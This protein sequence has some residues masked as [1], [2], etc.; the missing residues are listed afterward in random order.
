MLLAMGMKLFTNQSRMPTTIRATKIW[1]RGILFLPFCLC[2][3]TL[4]HFPR[5]AGGT[6]WCA[7]RV[8]SLRFNDGLTHRPGQSVRVTCCS[9]S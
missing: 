4:P 8:E 7:E 1:M 3:E 9:M 2:C 6:A 5:I